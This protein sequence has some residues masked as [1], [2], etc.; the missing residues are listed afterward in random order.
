MKASAKLR[1]V[2][3]TNNKNVMLTIKKNS[4]I[5]YIELFLIILSFRKIKYVLYEEVFYDDVID[6][7]CKYRITKGIYK[8]FNYIYINI[9]TDC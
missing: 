3:I 2:K 1:N 5:K 6:Y 4:A 7:L 9:L 8:S